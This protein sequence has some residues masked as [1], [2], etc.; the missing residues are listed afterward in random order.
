MREIEVKAKLIDAAAVETKLRAMGAK[1]SP[2]VRQADSVYLQN[3]TAFKDI[4]VNTPVLRIR[5]QTPG[6]ILL[7][8]KHIRGEELDKQEHEVAVSDGKEM[9]QI[10]ELSGFYQAVAFTKTRRKCAISGY[11]IC[12]DEVDG[13]GSFIEIEKLISDRQNGGKEVDGQDIQKELFHFLK[14]LGVSEHDKVLSGYD[15]LIYNGLNAKLKTQ[16]EK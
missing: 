11:E 9:A 3:G 15:V 1:L 7:T 8:Y 2:P 16:N 12:L 14:S 13:L 10:L 6:K 4:T 5:E